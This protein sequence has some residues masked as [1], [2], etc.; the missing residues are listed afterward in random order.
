LFALV[1]N[2]SRVEAQEAR[3]LELADGER[4]VFLGNAFVERSLPSGYL[5]TLLTQAFPDRN[6]TYRNLGWSGDNVHGHARA[7]FDAAAKGFSRIE[8]RI[9]ETK[10][11]TVFLAYGMVESFEG[12][13]GLPRFL[14][15]LE[16]L[17]KLIDGTK[18]RVVF[19][20][21][22]RHEKMPAPLPDPAAHNRQLELYCDA[23]RE[24][25]QKRGEIFIDLYRGLGDGADSAAKVKY[26]DNGIHLTDFGYWATSR[27][28]LGALGLEMPGTM[29]DIDL[30]RKPAMAAS[31]F[32]DA[33][34]F[35]GDANGLSFEVTARALPAPPRPA[36]EGAKAPPAPAR[37][38]KI[39]GLAK[40][41]YLISINDQ[42][43]AKAS[44]F[45]LAQGLSLAAS[46]EIAQVQELRRTIQ[47]KNSL[48]FYQWRPQNN[49]YL[50]LFRKHEQGHLAGEM[51]DF[52]PL[53]AAEE[54]R[55]AELREPKALEYKVYPENQE[56]LE[57]R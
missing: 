20:S 52:D 53:I 26:T 38:L 15:G 32:Q 19:L 43:V 56:A 49:T 54:K 17:L 51:K 18:P 3:A 29:I 9:R 2:S 41:R 46:P 30:S 22:I 55:I 31:G 35:D 4:V 45:E 12:E 34:N 47:Y 23:I 44:P 11:T 40:G 1:A 50:F 37:F 36:I 33:K 6:V 27:V 39:R 14:Q 7:G 8:R 48:Y 16:R 24:V 13:A 5:E 42:V 10:P 28:I 21:P 57:Q 25:A